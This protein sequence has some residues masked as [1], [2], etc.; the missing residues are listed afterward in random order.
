[1]N[2]ITNMM[3]IITAM[4]MTRMNIITIMITTMD[5]TDI[6]GA[7]AGR[8]IIAAGVAV[9]GLLA[10]LGANA[11]GASIWLHY[12]CKPLTTLLILA[13]V[14][15]IAD[16]VSGRY[17][18]MIMAGIVLSALGDIF[19][20]L[21]PAVF[22]LGFICG[23]ASFLVAHLLFLRALT[24]DVPLF[25]KPQALLIYAVI[26]AINLAI[27][28]SGLPAD[29]HV[30]VPV[31]LL[32]LAAMAAQAASRWLTLKTKASCMAACGGALFFLSDTLIAYDRFSQPIAFASVWILASYYTAIWLIALSADKGN[33]V[34]NH[35]Q[36]TKHH[37]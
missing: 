7:S 36:I 12:L 6:D 4:V 5:V 30:P 37:Y 16:P 23:L 14:W 34:F 22:A 25:G 2:I 31:Y 17:K 28:W 32:C 20:M 1:M 13:W 15:L 35:V 9:S 19:L 10:I 33:T 18:T 29:L 27:L 3:T 8:R 26:G 24:S 11:T 21:P